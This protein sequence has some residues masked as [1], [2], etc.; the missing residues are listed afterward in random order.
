MNLLTTMTSRCTCGAKVLS[1]VKASA[2][3]SFSYKMYHVARSAGLGTALKSSIYLRMLPLSIVKRTPL[4]A[5][6]NATRG[7]ATVQTLPPL[8]RAVRANGKLPRTKG[9]VYWR[10]STHH[11]P[12]SYP[13]PSYPKTII[14]AL[15]T[16]EP[17]RC[18]PSSVFKPLEKALLSMTRNQR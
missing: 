5:V 13:L 17:A 1:M 11:L 8:V 6:P 18:I 9:F 4:T 15:S 12:R 10:E 14:G 16:D 7:R 3:G 2:I